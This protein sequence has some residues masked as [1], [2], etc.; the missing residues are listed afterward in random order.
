MINKSVSS[1]IEK[2]DMF[3]HI[4]PVKYREAL[5]KKA[6]RGLYLEEQN[7]LEVHHNL[8]PALF[9]LENRFSMMD[10]FEGLRQVLTMITPPLELVTT[11]S[12]AAELAKMANDELAELVAKY[13]DR[14]VAGVACL[15]M[16]NIDA[17]YREAERAVSELNL[18]G[19]QLFTPCAGTPI[20]S[21]EFLPLYE[22]MARYD[23]PVW[24]HPLRGRDKQDYE[25]ESYSKYR[26]FH[27]LGW[28]YETTAAIMRLVFS[29]VLER[30]PNLKF[31]T[32]H[33]GGLLPFLVQ[34][35]VHQSKRAMKDKEPIEKDIGLSR[36]VLEYFKMFYGDTAI[37]GHIPGLMCGYA[38]FG[39]D[40]MVFGTDAPLGGADRIEAEIISVDGMKIPDLDRQ[41]IFEGNARRILHI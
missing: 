37:H 3:T 1:K 38:F 34:R 31:V 5:Y 40:H 21:P 25:D 10:K 19:I 17:A 6:Q 35:L 8:T 16:N 14:F 33:C 41:K 22:I 15:P 9:D 12:D 13:P 36:P 27:I 11:P 2:I 26:I 23:L 18:K 4:L 7:N 28:P 32:H 29:G 30:Y 20:D 39:A 24:I